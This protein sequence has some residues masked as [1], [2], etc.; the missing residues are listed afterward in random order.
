[1]KDS[2]LLDDNDTEENSDQEADESN[3]FVND[4]KLT[5]LPDN[6]MDVECANL[7]IPIL[8]QAESRASVP[9]LEVT[10][11]D[12]YQEDVNNVVS[13]NE[14]PIDEAN[15]LDEKTKRRGKK[16]AKEERLF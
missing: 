11:D 14:E 2:Y 13:Q 10:L 3:G 1:M 9:P 7:A 8:V 6:D 16:K 12:V 15:T 5:S 4:T